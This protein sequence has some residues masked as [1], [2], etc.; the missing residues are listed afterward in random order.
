M[1]KYK[2][3]LGIKHDYNDQT[4]ISLIADIYK[5][6]LQDDSLFTILWKWIGMNKG[7]HNHGSKWWKFIDSENFNKFLNE[8]AIKIDNIIDI[9]E[10]DVIMF[11]NLRRRIPI[12]FGMYIGQNM[13]IHMQEKSY[14]K[15]EMLSEMWR[16]R[17]HSVYRS[18][19]V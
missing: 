14:S 17:I 12:H 10:Y 19:M 3:Y 9:Q 4:C 11:S 1:E 8:Y 13:M 15:I 5:N 6:E 7:R 16:G 18:K 2:K